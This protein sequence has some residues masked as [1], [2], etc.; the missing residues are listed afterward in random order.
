M[1]FY[2]GSDQFSIWTLYLGKQFHPFLVI[3]RLLIL[4]KDLTLIFF[5]GI[6]TFKICR[7]VSLTSISLKHIVP[8]IDLHIVVG[9]S[10]EPYN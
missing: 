7:E 1:H 9:V 8:G 10:V 4:F 6:P 2:A 5:I 3:V